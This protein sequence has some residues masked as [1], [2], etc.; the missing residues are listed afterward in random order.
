MTNKLS[1]S[2]KKQSF[3]LK[4]SCME[5]AGP[6][7]ENNAGGSLYIGNEEVQGALGGKQEVASPIADLSCTRD[8]VTLGP[9][10]SFKW[11]EERRREERRITLHKE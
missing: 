2:G 7:C 9:N 1:T 11:Q 3:L 4:I 10:N 5:E 6:V 8:S